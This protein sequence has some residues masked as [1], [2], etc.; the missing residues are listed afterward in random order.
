MAR[1]KCDDKRP[2]TN[3]SK[4][5]RRTSSIQ[6][7]TVRQRL[8]REG[9][10]IQWIHGSQGRLVLPFL[11]QDATLT[12]F[13]DLIHRGVIPIAGELGSGVSFLD[14]VNL[15][16]GLSVLSAE[17][18]KDDEVPSWKWHDRDENILRRYSG[19]TAIAGYENWGRVWRYAIGGVNKGIWSGASEHFVATQ[20]VK[21][22]Q[23]T[24]YD[25]PPLEQCSLDQL[26]RYI[27]V[28]G[29]LRELSPEAYKKL[30]LTPTK[31]NRAKSLHHDRLQKR[32]DTYLAIRGLFL[33]HR[34]KFLSI[35]KVYSSTGT[36]SK[37]ELDL[38]NTLHLF[39]T[40]I[41]A[42][43]DLST[44]C[45]GGYVNGHGFLPQYFFKVDDDT[46]NCVD[47]IAK[48][49]V[50]LLVWHAWNT[51]TIPEGLGDM[52]ELHKSIDFLYHVLDPRTTVPTLSKVQIAFMENRA[53]LPIVFASTRTS[54]PG[55]DYDDRHEQAM[56]SPYLHLG[57]NG[58]DVLFTDS[59]ENKRVLD[60][61]LANRGL[62]DQVAVLAQFELTL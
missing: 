1:A 18:N 33:A 31:L 32:Q 55:F 54:I 27:I 9:R 53:T 62:A 37:E 14:G 35:Q 42:D 43:T 52:A 23:E 19:L 40:P 2:R 51:R 47:Y 45:R 30:K 3:T 11:E 7:D 21:W 28:V 44:K 60:A 56:S 20:H 6:N 29:Q 8:L 17:P 41:T 38:L 61:W 26:V 13:G 12:C 36:I 46:L 22:L 34:Y 48:V 4:K 58:V 49:A 15:N 59:T 25:L 50:E 10:Q 24:L 16:H 57:T 39:D 5:R